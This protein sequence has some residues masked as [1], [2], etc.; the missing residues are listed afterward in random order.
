MSYTLV[1]PFIIAILIGYLFGSIPTGYLYCK[2]KNINIFEMGS[3]NPGYTNVKR[4][5]GKKEG[6]KV[7]LLDVLKSYVPCIIVALIFPYNI[8]TEYTNSNIGVFYTLGYMAILYTGMGAVIGHS[9]PIFLHFKGGKG[10]ATTAGVMF[11]FN[12]IYCMF[13]ILVYKVV[14]KV[15]NYVS[16]GSLVAISVLSILATILSIFNIYPFNFTNS[17]MVLPACY[18]ITIVCFIKHRSNIMRLIEGKENK[19]VQ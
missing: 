7:L 8:Y 16:V 9:W 2:S 6:H 5:L 17:Y 18:I 15:S 12:P 1:L 3:G 4:V 14:S 10:I 13:L 19:I 11:A